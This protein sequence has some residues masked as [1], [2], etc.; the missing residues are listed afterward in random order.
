[1]RLQLL[2]DLELLLRYVWTLAASSNDH[3]IIYNHLG[4]KFVSLA[5]QKRLVIGLGLTAAAVALA[6]IPTAELR[7]KP[8]KPLFFYLTPLVRIQVS[9]TCLQLQITALG[10]AAS[11]AYGPSFAADTMHTVFAATAPT[12]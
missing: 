11:A 5:L 2:M 3:D 8:S 6:L 7:G 12:S 10:C 9:F 1:M 4:P